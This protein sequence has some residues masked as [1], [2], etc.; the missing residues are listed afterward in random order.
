LQSSRKYDLPRGIR[1]DPRSRK[2]VKPSEI[3]SFEENRAQT[4]VR[5]PSAGRLREMEFDSTDTVISNAFKY[6]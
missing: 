2:A 3:R 5:F 1:R 4:V 6:V